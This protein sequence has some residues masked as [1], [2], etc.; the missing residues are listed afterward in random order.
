MIV[1]MTKIQQSLSRFA[2]FQKLA[3]MGA[4]FEQLC[5]ASMTEKVKLRVDSTILTPNVA[6]W[7][8]GLE[9]QKSVSMSFGRCCS[10]LW[11]GWWVHCKP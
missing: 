6:G 4:A 3:E 11:F 2:S 10:V 7:R 9:A 8:R 1:A 5:M